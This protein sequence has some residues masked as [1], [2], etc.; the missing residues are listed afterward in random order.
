MRVYEILYENIKKNFMTLI[1]PNKFIINY[2]EN[3]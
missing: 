2:E 3:V 1:L